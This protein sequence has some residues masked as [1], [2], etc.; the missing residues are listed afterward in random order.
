MTSKTRIGSLM[1]TAGLAS[2]ILIPAAPAAQ[3]APGDWTQLSQTSSAAAYPKVRNIDVP[4][5]AWFGANLQVLWSQSQS[6][7]SQAYFTATLDSGGKVTTPATAAFEPWQTLTSDPT[8][9]S[10]GGQRFLSFSGLNPGR[11]GAQYFATSPDGLGWTVSSGSM[12]ETQSAYADYGSDAIDNA[13]TPVWVGNA[14]STTG[15]R[16]HVG[17]SASNPAPPGSD[18]SYTLGG[19]C[20]YSAA[21]ARD[22]AT[23]AV[24]AAFYSNSSATTENGIQVGQIIPSVANWKQAP[25]STDITDGRAASISTSQRVALVGRPGGGVYVAYVVGY[26][27]TRFVRVYNVVTGATLD[28][29]GSAGADAV[30][31]SAE[32][33]GRLWVTWRSSGK[34]KAVHT[35]PSATRFGSVG[36][37]GAPKGT[38]YLWKSAIAGTAGG[39]SVVVTATTQNAINVWHTRVS[40]TL[41]LV[42]SPAKVRRAAKVT[43]TVTDAG[44]AVA[45]AKV[46]FGSRTGTTNS[47][48]KVTLR[49]PGS[50]GKVKA[51]AAKGA[52]NPGTTAVRV[53]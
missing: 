13:G 19:C 18:Q 39:A 2:A 5:L 26:P 32:P 27:T 49:A 7:G 9:L 10:L 31:M 4:T 35:N 42:S 37:W 43:F 22:A 3:A 29:P 30:A 21:A 36:N 40:R 48:G 33:D 12:S 46:K 38:E 1:A 45:G 44:D 15:I 16:W 14:G 17:T 23:G 34:V 8:L 51:T 6:A 28:V 25:G 52:Y 50:A 47:A 20:A 11:T 41:T 24:Y 53:R